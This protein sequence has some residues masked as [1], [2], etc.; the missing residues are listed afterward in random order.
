[1]IFDYTPDMDETGTRYKAEIGNL[2]TRFDIAPVSYNLS[3]SHGEPR[4]SQCPRMHVCV[5][6][7][8]CDA[9]IDPRKS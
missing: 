7:L 8:I 5:A 9:M 3:L 4:Q 2:H 6:C 1:M